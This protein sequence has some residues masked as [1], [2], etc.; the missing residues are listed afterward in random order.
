MN[1]LR[2]VA[3]NRTK[4]VS[5]APWDREESGPLFCGDSAKSNKSSR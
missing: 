4:T 1:M 5:R 2:Q 3:D